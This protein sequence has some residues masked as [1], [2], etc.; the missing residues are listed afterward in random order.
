[1]TTESNKDLAKQWIYSLEHEPAAMGALM[2]PN[3][4]I[5][6]SNDGIWKTPEEARQNAVKR[7]IGKDKMPRFEDARAEVTERGIV[8]QATLLGMSDVPVH[9]VQLLTVEDGVVAVIEEYLA[10]E[11]PSLP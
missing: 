5:W 9:V 1:M 8:V 11:N 6:H 2:L 7:G 4:R 10:P 3:V